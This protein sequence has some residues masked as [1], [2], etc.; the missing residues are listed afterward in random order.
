[1]PRKKLLFLICLFIVLAIIGAYVYINN[2]F[3]QYLPYQLASEGSFDEV[4]SYLVQHPEF[5]INT[6]SPDGKTMLSYAL[7]NIDYRI[8]KLLISFKADVNLAD[9]QEPWVSPLMRAI[10]YQRM[11]AFTY[12]MNAKA[13]YNYTTPDNI[14]TPFFIAA[15]A[16]CGNT[17]IMDVLYE[18]GIDVNYRNAEGET[19]LLFALAGEPCEVTLRWFVDHGANVNDVAN[20]GE[21]ALMYAIRYSKSFMPLRF[22][23]DSGADVNYTKKNGKTV[24]D[25]A[26]ESDS[27]PEI[28]E[29]L[30]NAGAKANYYRDAS[31]KVE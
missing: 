3:K 5:D 7:D 19:A 4:V 11:H 8:V 23:I 29:I 6:Y 22:L 14:L 28:I 1:M 26:Y 10:R 31:E 20:N 2:K 18:Y 27:H 24:L 30:K 25:I 13:N 9:K 12:L 15:Y 17:V 16:E 21:S